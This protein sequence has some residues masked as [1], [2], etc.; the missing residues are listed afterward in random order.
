MPNNKRLSEKKNRGPAD[1][2]SIFM[3]ITGFAA[4]F[5]LSLAAGNSV[6]FS[7][8]CAIAFAAVFRFLPVFAEKR[9]KKK[10]LKLY[11]I[12]MADYLIGV[13]L[14]MSSGMTVWESLRRA[15]AGADLGRP[16]YR[17]IEMLFE[18]IDAG[19]Y[20]DP[21]EAFEELASECGSPAVSTLTAAIVQNYKK[22]SGE[23]AAL[24]RDL[25]LTARNNRKYICM[26]LADEA[27]TLL[28]IPSTLILV[29]L[30]VL[31]VAPAVMTLT[32]L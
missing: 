9:K 15:L 24:L 31:L 20:G 16:L 25:S 23:I 11:E 2:K 28:L 22:G 29:A 17:D 26:K 21:V 12:D 30:I 19:K 6:L 14:L 1:K 7:V 27:T 10:E 8:C 3:T 4:G 32:E 18:G 13:S 5:A